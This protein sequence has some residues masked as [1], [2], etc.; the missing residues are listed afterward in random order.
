MPGSVIDEDLF[1][2][3]ANDPQADAA[4]FEW[5]NNANIAAGSMLLLQSW[6]EIEDEVQREYE[7][8]GL[9]NHVDDDS[10][11]KVRVR[12]EDGVLCF[13]EGG[14]GQE[15]LVRVGVPLRCCALL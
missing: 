3:Y 11:V 10:I 8:W 2:K 12:G 14:T 6:F 13:F 9:V 15:R 5:L 1:R 4:H 7:Y